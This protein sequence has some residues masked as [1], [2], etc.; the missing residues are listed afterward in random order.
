[1]LMAPAAPQLFLLN[2]EYAAEPSSHGVV[3][4]TKVA[5]TWDDVAG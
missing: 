1:M 3:A 2:A 5:E 4:V